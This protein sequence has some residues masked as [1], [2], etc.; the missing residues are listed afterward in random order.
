MTGIFFFIMK[1]L[2][3]Y[4]FCYIARSMKNIDKKTG[5][6]HY[7]QE[8]FL[9]IIFLYGLCIP[10]ILIKEKYVISVCIIIYTSNFQNSQIFTKLIRLIDYLIIL[11]LLLESEEMELFIFTTFIN[12]KELTSDLK[13]NLK[14]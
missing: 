1:N 3:F 14:C 8:S 11:A 7:F 9:S 5:Y 6:R 13:N 4:N 2:L 12:E 10:K